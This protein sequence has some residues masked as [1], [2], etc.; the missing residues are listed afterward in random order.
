MRSP[1]YSKSTKRT[2]ANTYEYSLKFPIFVP[3][4]LK[5]DPTSCKQQ[6][7]SMVCM[8]F[9]I[10]KYELPYLE[11]KFPSQSGSASF[12]SGLGVY[13]KKGSSFVVCVHL[14]RFFP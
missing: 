7:H 12:L 9:F 6:I 10:S 5:N 3:P 4:S 13:H 2:F 1:L 11:V 14:C 8:E